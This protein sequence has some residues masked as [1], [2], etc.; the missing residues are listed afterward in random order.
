MK[1]IP[2]NSVY[3]PLHPTRPEVLNLLKVPCSLLSPN[4]YFCCSVNLAYPTPLLMNVVSSEQ[5]FLAHRPGLDFC[6]KANWDQ[7]ASV[8]LGQRHAWMI[9]GFLWQ[10]AIQEERGKCI[11][12]ACIH[13]VMTK[14]RTW[15]S[16]CP[17]FH[18]TRWL[19]LPRT[20]WLVFTKPLLSVRWG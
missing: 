20:I 13:K 15:Q 6:D 16:H 12:N 5:I 2:L 10:P 14:W 3:N 7:P 11:L 1:P 8:F 19:P 18:P 9:A 4:L 17:V